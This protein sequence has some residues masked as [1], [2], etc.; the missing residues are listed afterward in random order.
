MILTKLETGQQI[1][2]LSTLQQQLE[3]ES[4]GTTIDVQDLPQKGSKSVIIKL[5]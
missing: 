2:F 3:W 1:F 5:D 4:E